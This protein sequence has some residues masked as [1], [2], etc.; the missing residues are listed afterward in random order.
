MIS[1]GGV[2]LIYPETQTV[3]KTTISKFLHFYPTSQRSSLLEK[4]QTSWGVF[5]AVDSM[6]AGGLS[7]VYDL[8][9]IFPQNQEI[10]SHFQQS[11]SWGAQLANVSS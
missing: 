4:L 7:V 9:P 6:G 3:L 10:L 5:R 2:S 1:W 11:H 8:L